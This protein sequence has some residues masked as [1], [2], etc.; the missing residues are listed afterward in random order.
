MQEEGVR[1]SGARSEGIRCPGARGEAV[2]SHLMSLLSN[3]CH[4][5]E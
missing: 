4:L 5:E 3:S 2:V 1:C